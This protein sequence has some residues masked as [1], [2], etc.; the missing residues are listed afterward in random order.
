MRRLYQFIV[1]FFYKT[2]TN[3]LHCWLDLNN[4]FVLHICAIF[5]HFNPKDGTY[6]LDNILEMEPHFKAE[7]P[8]AF[9]SNILNN[10]ENTF[11]HIIQNLWDS[12]RLTILMLLIVFGR[13]AD[14]FTWP[15]KTVLQK[16]TNKQKNFTVIAQVW[17]H[18]CQSPQTDHTG[19]RQ[20]SDFHKFCSHTQKKLFLI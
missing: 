19:K 1:I 18:F 11:Q 7:T 16:L 10:L 14:F 12:F 9:P 3:N 13:K 5:S 17:G 4:I 8:K 2:L 6:S 20:V 15:S